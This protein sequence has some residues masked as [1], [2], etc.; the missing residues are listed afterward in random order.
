MVARAVEHLLATDQKNVEKPRVMEFNL[1]F[2]PL[3]QPDNSKCGFTAV[4]SMVLGYLDSTKGMSESDILNLNRIM[5]DWWERNRIEDVGRGNSYNIGIDIYNL[6]RL[7]LAINKEFDLKCDMKISASGAVQKSLEDTINGLN[8]DNPSRRIR[9]ES[10]VV[11]KT[12]K[13]QDRNSVDFDTNALTEKEIIEAVKN[14]EYVIFNSQDHWMLA[15][16][17]IDKRYPGGRIEEELFIS[18]PANSEKATVFK[19]S[20]RYFNS[21]YLTE[22][23][24]PVIR[25]K[26]TPPPDVRSRELEE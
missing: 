20:T 19:N 13:D 11:Y 26:F 5:E 17:I 4:K 16:G 10:E 24:Y 12:L 23:R 7:I 8:M 15:C 25:V 18:N 14:D 9:L 2:V 22:D 6:S 3:T 21:T 1:A